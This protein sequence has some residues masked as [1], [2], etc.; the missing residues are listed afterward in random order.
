M[1]LDIFFVHFFNLLKG[2][3]NYAVNFYHAEGN[4]SPTIRT[5][6]GPIRADWR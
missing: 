1:N 3:F 4:L 5:V 2:G 6:S